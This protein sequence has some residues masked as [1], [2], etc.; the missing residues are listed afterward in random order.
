MPRIESLEAGIAA[1][2][3]AVAA[4]DFYAQPWEVTS[5][6]LAALEEKQ[7]EHALATERWI[8]LEDL[9]RQTGRPA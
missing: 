8:E 6:A 2:E 7:R 5:A 1:L 4:P 9:R 3:A